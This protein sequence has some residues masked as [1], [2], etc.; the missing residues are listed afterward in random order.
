MVREAFALGDSVRRLLVLLCALLFGYTT[1]IGWGYYGEQF[2]TYLAGAADHPAL[3]LTYCALVVV[4][5]TTSVELVWSWGDLMNGLQIFPNL[6]ASSGSPVSSPPCSRRMRR[7]CARVAIRGTMRYVIGIDAGGTKTTGMLG[8]RHRQGAARGA[9]RRR[10]SARSRRARRREVALS[11]PRRARLAAV[12]STPSA[13]ASPASAATPSATSCAIC[14][15][16]SASAARY[17]S[18]TTPSSR[19]SPALRKASASC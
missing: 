7:G 3:S 12:P 9:R 13:S 10:Q 5:A 19:W 14:C 4:G 6:S 2:L 1:L 16:A 17:G 11:G 8:R 18:S 15:A